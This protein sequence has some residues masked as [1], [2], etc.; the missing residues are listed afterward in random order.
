MNWFKIFNPV[1]KKWRQQHEEQGRYGSHVVFTQDEAC[2][3][4]WSEAELRWM[5]L[6]EGSELIA[7]NPS[8]EDIRFRYWE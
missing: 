2:A 1:T 4:F 3:G 8:R 6:P 5:T 7:F